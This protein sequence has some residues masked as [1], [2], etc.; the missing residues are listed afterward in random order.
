M[1]QKRSDILEN[2]LTQGCH[3]AASRAWI[4]E[5]PGHTSDD[6]RFWGSTA[7]TE[8]QTHFIGNVGSRLVGPK[9]GTA[10]MRTIE[11]LKRLRPSGRWVL[12]AIDPNTQKITTITAKDEAQA[13][14]FIA[15]NN[16]KRNLYYSVNPTRDSNEQEGREDRY[17]R[18]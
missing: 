16:G 12:T 4:K 9:E 6:F 14:K 13:D 3:R 17:R 10:R 8:E 7:A 2:L 5:H 1:K 11:F 18:R 15:A